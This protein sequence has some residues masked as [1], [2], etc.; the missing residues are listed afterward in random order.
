MLILFCLLLLAG[1]IF[2]LIKF[3]RKCNDLFFVLGVLCLVSF[4]VLLWFSSIRFVEY[5]TIKSVIDTKIAIYEEE[6]ARIEQ[7]LQKQGVFSEFNVDELFSEPELN[8]FFQEQ[9]NNYR[10][11]EK[12]KAEKN[13]IENELLLLYFYHS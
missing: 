1:G 3:T 6:N 4:F 12:L 7:Y 2:A 9:F 11:I 5:T 10:Q 8:V 13:G